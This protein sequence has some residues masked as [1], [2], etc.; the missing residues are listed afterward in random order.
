MILFIVCQKRGKS[1]RRDEECAVCQDVPTDPC[2]VPCGNN[3]VFCL[4]CLQGLVSHN[5]HRRTFPC[6]LC[7]TRVKIPLRGL[8]VL[9]NDKDFRD[10]VMAKLPALKP[11][12][13]RQRS[14]STSSSVSSS[15]LPNDV[16]E[17]VIP[18]EHLSD[19]S[20]GI[21][22]SLL[23]AFGDVPMGRLY[24]DTLT[25]RNRLLEDSLDS[26]DDFPLGAVDVQ[27]QRRILE[28]I[29]RERGAGLVPASPGSPPRLLAP[30]PDDDESLFD[31]DDDALASAADY[32]IHGPETEAGGEN[33]LVLSKSGDDPG[34]PRSEHSAHTPTLEHVAHTPRGEVLDGGE[35]RAPTP[36][37]GA[38]SDDLDMSVV[39]QLIADMDR[40]S[41]SSD[42]RDTPRSFSS[43]TSSE[44][45]VLIARPSG[46][47]NRSDRNSGRS[48][49]NGRASSARRRQLRGEESAES[50]SEPRRDSASEDED[51]KH[52]RAGHWIPR[53]K[54]LPEELTS[55]ARKPHALRSGGS[56]T[57]TSPRRAHQHVSPD[58]SSR[59]REDYDLVPE[60]RSPQNNPYRRQRASNPENSAV[61]PSEEERYDHNTSFGGTTPDG[62]PE[63]SRSS[64]KRSQT[65]PGDRRNHTKRVSR[66]RSVGGNHSARHAS[67][68]D[69][70]R[71]RSE[72]VRDAS[73]SSGL[74][75]TTGDRDEYAENLRRVSS[76]LQPRSRVSRSDA[77]NPRELAAPTE[78]V[79]QDRKSAKKVTVI[80]V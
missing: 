64:G 61:F 9:K 63:D 27:L 18:W 34:T 40:N 65:P 76:L 12:C 13:R 24:L 22:P 23:E 49:E 6:P 72:S 2:T 51:W 79:E 35:E 36:I 32:D 29:E 33:W 75:T 42:P 52:S 68:E 8:A 43:Q 28:D 1:S 41:D 15:W 74:S 37:P 16:L 73:T 55:G 50:S 14:N 26:S 20:G 57:D 25:R 10:K 31:D 39:M 59:D 60:T 4:A 11:R 19:G 54:F 66:V 48:D 21:D 53:P 62:G 44:D 80:T 56:P 70:H 38:V 3:H 58:G 77:A 67:A 71:R 46:D 17:V 69:R 47:R 45:P 7:R 78:S 5:E 30:L